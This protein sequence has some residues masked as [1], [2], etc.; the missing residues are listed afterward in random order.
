MY[1]CARL[2]IHSRLRTAGVCVSHS[3]SIPVRQGL[4]SMEV[5]VFRWAGNEQTPVSPLVSAP[6]SLARDHAWLMMWVLR[7]ELGWVLRVQ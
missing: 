7:S 5:P 3:L 2:C 1:M 4:S 6:A